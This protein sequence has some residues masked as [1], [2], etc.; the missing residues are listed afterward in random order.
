MIKKEAITR[1]NGI[2]WKLYF[3]R[4]GN[5]DASGKI[6]VPLVDAIP[7][8]FQGPIIRYTI[9]PDATK[10]RPNPPKISCTLNLTLRNPHNRP[11]N[12]P[13]IRPINI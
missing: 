8:L 12:P 2:I 7:A 5:Q 11:H 13:K 1:I 4:V 6:S 10:S 9:N 3:P